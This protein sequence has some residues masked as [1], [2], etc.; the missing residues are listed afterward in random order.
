MTE[1]QPVETDPSATKGDEIVLGERPAGDALVLE[2][3]RSRI[4]DALFATGERV[5][6]GRYQL[7]KRAG[8][9]GMGVVWSAWD[10]ELER[11]VAIK[12]MHVRSEAARAHMLREG[13]S[14]AKLSHPNVVP[15]HDVGSVDDQVYLVMEWIAG[16]TLRVHCEQPRTLRALVAIYLAAG[17]GVAAAHR[18]GIVQRDFKPDNVMIGDD[19]RVRVLDFGIARFEDAP[20]DSVAGTPRYMAPEQARGEAPTVAADQY[21]FGISLGE[22]LATRG[23]VPTWIATIITRATAPKASDRYPDM[24]ALLAALAH[25]PARRWRRRAA[26]AAVLVVAGGAFAIGTLRADPDDA[27]SGAGDELARVWNPKRSAELVAHV[28][29]L[30]PYGAAQARLL[31]GQLAAYGTRWTGAR[32]G[33]CHARRRGEVTT[34]L[35]ERGLACIER[36]RAALDGVAAAMTR[37]SLD[38]FPNAVV[39]ARDLPDAERCLAEATADLISPPRPA[40]AAEVSRVGASATKARFLALAS[41]PAALPLARD[42]ARSPIAGVSAAR[43]A[44]PAGTRCGTS[45]HPSTQAFDAYRVASEA[46]L[47]AGDDL[48]FVEAFA[49]DL[50]VVTRRHQARAPTL[51]STLP[52]VATIAGAR[53]AAGSRAPC[54]TT[55]P[56]PR[57]SR[58]A[59]PQPRLAGFARPGPSPTTRPAAPS[60]G[61][62]SA[63]RDGVRARG[64]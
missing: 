15:I 55:T 51:A 16:E 53:E 26:I 31:A 19:G 32:R 57:R 24:D 29:T 4:A 17:A 39:A 36:S 18:A 37:A 45:R 46:A 60:C 59:I 22:S 13:Q 30:G 1:D 27:C 61:R 34:M 5:A 40:I 8:A 20:G 41:D 23:E 43:R 62:S 42:A 38:Q 28:A 54:S 25:D 33:A 56:A 63:P 12:L 9:G 6:V 11:R 49:R 52:F 21:S 35:Y 7:L 14:L 44:R 47:Q 2:V 10:P 58:R 64:T 48:A 3:A 50:F